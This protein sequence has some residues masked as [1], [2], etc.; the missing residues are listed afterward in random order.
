M[1]IYFAA[2]LSKC[3]FL[4]LLAEDSTIIT[5]S[6]YIFVQFLFFPPQQLRGIWQR[7]HSAPQRTP[8]KEVHVIFRFIIEINKNMDFVTVGL[9]FSHFK[10]KT[11]SEMLPKRRSA[12][13]YRPMAFKGDILDS[14]NAVPGLTFPCLDTAFL[15]FHH[16]T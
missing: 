13:I 15:F 16:Y 14:Q 9:S 8:L 4:Y 3:F 10:P 11:K 2:L 7:H 1:N 5:N 6:N 12:T